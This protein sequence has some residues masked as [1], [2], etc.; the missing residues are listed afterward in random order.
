M[1]RLYVSD[2]DGT[3]LNQQAE[4]SDVTIDVIK[5]AIA[6]GLDFTVSTARTP[7]TALKI[8]EPLHLQLPV[9]MMNGVLVYDM[10]TKKYLK[11]RQLK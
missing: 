7:T 2:L 4:L 9:M 3:L 11:K 5:R 8:V 1:K 10:A 6:Q